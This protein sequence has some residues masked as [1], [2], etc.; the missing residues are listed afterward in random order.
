MTPSRGRSARLEGTDGA[1]ALATAHVS[2]RG[3]ARKFNAR[4]SCLLV[5]LV[6]ATSDGSTGT[7][8]CCR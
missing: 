8:P 5:A 2:T 4:G 7:L 1:R 6:A 3:R